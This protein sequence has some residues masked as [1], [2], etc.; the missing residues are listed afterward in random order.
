VF[1][2]RI[3]AKTAQNVYACGAIERTQARVL[4]FLQFENGC[5]AAE[6]ATVIRRRVD[7]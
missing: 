6:F 5:D 3:A 4:L 2:E 7:C 1:I